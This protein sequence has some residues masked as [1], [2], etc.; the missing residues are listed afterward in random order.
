MMS[1]Y[2]QIKYSGTNLKKVKL[3]KNI[4]SHLNLSLNLQIIPMSQVKVKLIFREL[5]K[6]H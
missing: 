2:N 3:N 4:T 5:L 1:K 6:S